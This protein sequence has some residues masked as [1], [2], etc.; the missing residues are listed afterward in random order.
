M[1]SEGGWAVP[2]RPCAKS[3]AKLPERGCTCPAGLCN[4]V[5]FDRHGP[6]CVG[7]LASGGVVRKHQGWQSQAAPPGPDEPV[8]PHQPAA[9]RRGRPGFFKLRLPACQQKPSQVTDVGWGWGNGQSPHIHLERQ[10][11]PTGHLAPLHPRELRPRGGP[12]LAQ[13]LPVS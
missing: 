10:A 8:H 3:P 2:C 6:F 7:H 13:V 9:Y 12:G 1:D 11:G 4:S 5:S